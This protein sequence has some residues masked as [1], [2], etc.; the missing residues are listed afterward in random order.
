[1]TA[2]GTDMYLAQQKR[3]VDFMLGQDGE[4]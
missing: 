1:V 4:E 2:T 3:M